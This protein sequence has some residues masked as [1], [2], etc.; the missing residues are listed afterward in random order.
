MVLPSDITN[1]REVK[2][3][4]VHRQP[5]TSR[6]HIRFRIDSF[7]GLEEKVIVIHN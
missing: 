4:V 6:P 1:Q 2:K 5:E 3:N 7:G